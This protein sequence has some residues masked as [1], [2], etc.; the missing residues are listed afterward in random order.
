MKIHPGFL[1][2]GP[3]GAMIL[4]SVNSLELI[5]KLPT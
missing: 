1:A 5:F 2:K 3:V 4:A